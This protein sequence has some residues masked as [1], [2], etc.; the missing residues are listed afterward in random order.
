[1]L[2]DDPTTHVDTVVIIKIDFQGSED[3]SGIKNVTDFLKGYNYSSID[4]I[5]IQGDDDKSFLRTTYT[6]YYQSIYIDAEEYELLKTISEGRWLSVNT[7]FTSL[8][9]HAHD[10]TRDMVTGMAWSINLVNPDPDAGEYTPIQLPLLGF[11]VNVIYIRACDEV[12]ESCA[13]ATTD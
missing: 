2:L 4:K 9:K 13:S 11:A 1:M 12:P 10:N 3:K 6:K 7:A 5:I 8:I